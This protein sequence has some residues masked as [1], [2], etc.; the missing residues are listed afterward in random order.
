MLH[1]RIDAYTVRA[2]VSDVRVHVG[3]CMKCAQVRA[4][5]VCVPMLSSF[6]RFETLLTY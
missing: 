5:L 6:G 4:G 1:V 2:D 3:A